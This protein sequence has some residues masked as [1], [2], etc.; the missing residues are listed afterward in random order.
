MLLILNFYFLL[1]TK[2]TYFPCDYS[3]IIAAVVQNNIIKHALQH[4]IIDNITE[5]ISVLH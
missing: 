4:N 1:P 2:L 3:D 5:V